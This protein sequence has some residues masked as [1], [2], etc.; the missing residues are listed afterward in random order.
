LLKPGERAPP[1][2]L[3]KYPPCM[4]GILNPS[5]VPQVQTDGVVA[6]PKGQRPLFKID[7]YNGTTSLET[8][9]LQFK[10]LAVYLQW[11]ERDTFY[12]MCASLAG[13]AARVLW[14]LPKGATTADLTRLLQVRFGTDQ[15]TASFRAKLRA[16]HREPGASLQT[17]YQEMSHLLQLAYPGEGER[18]ISH[19]AVDT[20]ITALNDR[21]LEYEVLKLAPVT[22]EEAA[23]HAMR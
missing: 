16:R 19:L 3:I 18:F 10:Q 7:K 12:N 14:E 22:L 20:F 5:S 23:N 13:P 4:V 15:Q 2:I 9:L 1:L 8:Y 21:E 11:T 6:E 17:L